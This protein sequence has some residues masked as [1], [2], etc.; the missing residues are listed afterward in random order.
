MG[1]VTTQGVTSEM[2]GTSAR[3][4]SKDMGVSA[5]DAAPTETSRILP[6]A[7]KLDEKR[8][9]VAFPRGVVVTEDADPEEILTSLAAGAGD[10]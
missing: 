3:F 7:A 10:S 1:L 9:V 5:E 4:L 2:D 6:S 8:E